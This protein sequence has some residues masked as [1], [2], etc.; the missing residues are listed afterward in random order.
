MYKQGKMFKRIPLG[1]PYGF[2]PASVSLELLRNF[3]T[4]HEHA[5]SSCTSCRMHGKSAPRLL[6]H[7]LVVFN[8]E[9]LVRSAL[10]LG[11]CGCFQGMNLFER[12]FAPKKTTTKKAPSNRF[13]V[14][15]DSWNL[16]FNISDQYLHP[17]LTSGRKPCC[18]FRAST[19]V[20]FPYFSVLFP[21]DQTPIECMQRPISINDNQ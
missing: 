7:G 15:G 20:T 16:L 3:L 19:L 8:I 2:D 12:K 4:C 10:I 1:G 14:D 17:T 21:L 13:S 5:T 9:L 6:L 11:S 18:A